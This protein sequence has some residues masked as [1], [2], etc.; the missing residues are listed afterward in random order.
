[1]SDPLD[2][3]E[4]FHSHLHLFLKR[5]VEVFD[6]CDK[7]MG[8]YVAHEGFLDTT[9]PLA[10]FNKSMRLKIIKE[11]HQNMSPLYQSCRDRD[12]VPLLL[13]D[14]PILKKLDFASKWHELEECK[15]ST[16]NIWESINILNQLAVLYN[17]VPQKIIQLVQKV[18]SKSIDDVTD[19]K[20]KMSDIPFADIAREL[21]D[22]V[23]EVDIESIINGV[24]D[25]MNSID[26]Q[27]YKNEGVNVPELNLLS[28]LFGGS[29]GPKKEPTPIE[30]K[31]GKWKPSHR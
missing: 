13:A 9:G 2:A 28:S 14:V 10:S 6:D 24:G 23:D 30:P 1:M 31:F 25:L 17:I 11:W 5:I 7:S 27:S 20:K 26:L 29:S 16:G 8:Y 21:R 22:N 3:L 15:E 4:A 12:I 18:A 19:K